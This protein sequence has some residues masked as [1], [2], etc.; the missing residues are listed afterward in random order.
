[1]P[2]TGHY[3]RWKENTENLV[4]VQVSHPRPLKQVTD[5]HVCSI[6]Q[7]EE[8]DVLLVIELNVSFFLL[9]KDPFLG[10]II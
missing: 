2:H 5:E 9:Q 10:G 8:E 3:C 6:L 4:F 1:M 7:V